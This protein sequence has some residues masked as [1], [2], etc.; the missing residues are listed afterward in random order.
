MLVTI[1]SMHCYTLVSDNFCVGIVA[2]YVQWLADEPV[3]GN[4]IN[5]TI[6]QLFD[7]VPV[8][9]KVHVGTPREILLVD[10][11]ELQAQLDTS[12][13]DRTYV[14]GRC[15]LTSFQRHRARHNLTIRKTVV[16]VGCQIDAILQETQVQTEVKFLYLLPDEGCVH[17]SVRVITLY[18]GTTECHVCRTC[19]RSDGYIVAH[20]VV[21]CN[22]I[23]YTEFGI[24]KPR[25]ELLHPCLIRDA[26]C[27]S[28]RWEPSPAVAIGKTGAAIGTECGCC[29]ISSLVRI[30]G[31]EGE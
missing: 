12:V 16:E 23:R 21:T 24:I 9:G 10:D 18:F 29:H 1:H 28:Y 20:I 6:T 31:T 14:E 13:L 5:L 11:I 26:P 7:F 4:F 27:R 15:L 3:V 2:E 30:V 19:R 22:T 17:Q 25:T 8:A